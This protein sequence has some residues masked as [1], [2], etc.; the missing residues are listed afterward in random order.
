MGREGRVRKASQNE[1]SLIEFRSGVGELVLMPRIR[2]GVG[3][4]ECG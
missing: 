2:T 4:R 1:L 3:C